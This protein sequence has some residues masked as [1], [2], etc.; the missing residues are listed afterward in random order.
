MLDTFWVISLHIYVADNSAARQNNNKS[1]VGDWDISIS[2][3]PIHVS[4]R[5]D[6]PGV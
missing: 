4:F 1:R 3:A 2:V 5:V 6:A